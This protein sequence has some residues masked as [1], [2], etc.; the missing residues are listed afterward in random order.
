[1]ASVRIEQVGAAAG[2][3]RP[4]IRPDRAQDDNDA[5]G[6]VLAAVL[7]EA[8]DDGLRAGIPDREPHPGPPDQVQPPA[9]R[10]VQAGV[11]GDRLAARVGREVGL[12]G[13]D[14]PPARQALADV[15]VG[16]ADEPQV[17]SWPGERT[18]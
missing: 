6:H 2:H 18:E 8:L 14:E 9:G 4:E 11:A 13:D 1:M 10:A 5:A 3:P 17:E 12:R 7:A 16:L 15:I